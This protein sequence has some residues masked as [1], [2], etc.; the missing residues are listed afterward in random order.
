[1][2]APLS[3]KSSMLRPVAGIFA[4]NA[5]LIF[6]QVLKKAGVNGLQVLGVKLPL[7]R[8]VSKLRNSKGNKVILA[9]APR[10]LLG[11]LLLVVHGL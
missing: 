5:W 7:D 9:G 10:R 2:D 4:R 11:P 3:F 6:R 1:M 8:I